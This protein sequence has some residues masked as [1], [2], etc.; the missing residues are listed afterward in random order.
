[1]SDKKK[2]ILKQAGIYSVAT[3]IAQAITIIASICSRRFLGPTQ[4]GI[5][6]TLQIIVDYS[7]YT[8]LGI[9]AAVSREIPYAIGKKDPA[10]AQKIQNVAFSF[11]TSTSVLFAL[12]V[13]IFSLVS[14]G[15]FRP[16]ISYG[17]CLVSVLVFMQRFNNLLVA[18]LRSR[19]KFEIETELMVLSAIVNAALVAGLTYYFQIFGFIC[20]LIGSLG[21]NIAYIFFRNDFKFRYDMDRSELKP[22]LSFGLPL[23]ALGGMTTIFKSLDEI[24]VVR[25]LGFEQL[26][27]YSI[28]VMVFSYMTNFTASCAIILLPHFQ[29]KF[30]K[31]DNPKEMANYLLKSIQAYALIVPVFIGGVWLFAPFFIH[32][33]LPN[34]EP[35]LA[36][37]K[38]LVFNMFFVSV[39]QTPQ[40]F[41]MTI[42]KHWVLFPILAGSIALSALLDYWAVKAG[43]G[44]MGVAAATLTVFFLNFTA[45]FFAAA[46]FAV[47]RLT[48]IKRYLGWISMCAY[49][50]LILWA[51]DKWGGLENFDFFQTV[52]CAFIFVLAYMPFLWL[53]EKDFV[54]FTILRTWIRKRKSQNKP[55]NPKP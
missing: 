44:I 11:V 19:K 17:L 7:K 43:Y 28:A 54:V 12:A 37:M 52:R 32:W 34:F 41:L 14:W 6:A 26:G 3:Q 23:M 51:L 16:E 46:R 36:P 45:V 47:D 39:V 18:L 35:G 2:E 29:E 24:M 22:L 15:R 30:G 49:N 10:R 48:A 8:T 1:M 13:F 42:K 40:D 25:L 33:F 9:M 31:T 53:L 5:W 50:M 20:A 38:I 21:F 4:T 27:Y 55:A